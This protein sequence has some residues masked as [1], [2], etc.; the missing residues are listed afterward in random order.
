VLV[1]VRRN[2]RDLGDLLRSGDGALVLLEELNDGLDGSLGTTT[3]VHGVATS[4]DVLDTL[5]IDGAGENGGGGGSVSGLLVSLGS[6]VL[7]KT[8][9]KDRSVE[10]S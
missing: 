10:G 3:K 5:G 2:G 9:S 8:V 4:G 1:T 7:D 6:D